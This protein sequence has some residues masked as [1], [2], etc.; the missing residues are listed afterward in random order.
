MIGERH[1]EAEAGM[2]PVF[3]TPK[4]PGSF[5]RGRGRNPGGV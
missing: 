5:T 4:D 1:G 3:V 2:K